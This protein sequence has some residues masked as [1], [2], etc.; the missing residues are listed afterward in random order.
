M[1]ARCMGRAAQTSTTMRGTRQVGSM[2]AMPSFK[3]GSLSFSC[4]RGLCSG[5]RPS[6]AFS[7]PAWEP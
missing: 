2:E 6:V 5:I 4:P 1:I 3:P 7:L